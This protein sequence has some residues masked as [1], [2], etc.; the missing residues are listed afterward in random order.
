M[1]DIYAAF[2]NCTSV[3]RASDSMR[4]PTYT[5]SYSFLLVGA[6]DS[7]LLRGPPGFNWCFSF[8]KDFSRLFGPQGSTSSGS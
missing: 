8:A 3:G 7:C 2:F 1:V 5:C 4:A 6:G